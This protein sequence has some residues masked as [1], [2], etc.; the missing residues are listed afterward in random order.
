MRTCASVM[1]V[2]VVLFASSLAAV[3]A[4]PAV[5]AHG[6]FQSQ[7]HIAGQWFEVQIAFNVQDRGDVGDRGN[8]SMR[9]FDHWTGKLV[10]VLVSEGEMDVFLDGDWV[11]FTTALR[12]TFFDP[13]YYLPLHL[14]PAVT[15]QALD[16]GE[17]DEFK[18][19]LAPLPVEKGKIV[20]R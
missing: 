20:V 13:D 5:T 12:P 2:V 14:F 19:F 7:F 8:L 15:F 4:R 16:G 6:E 17:D 10:A 1:L 18:V 11:L 9:A 3:C